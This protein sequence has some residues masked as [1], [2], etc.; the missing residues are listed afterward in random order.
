MQP[1]P[2]PFSME[3]IFEAHAAAVSDP[4]TLTY[5][6]AMRDKDAPK[7][8]ASA[9]G[10]LL[11]LKKMNTWKVVPR[12]TAKTKILPGLWVFRRKRN[13]GT[14]EI[15]KYKG[16]Y[17]VR[18]DLQHGV[19]DTFAPVVQWSTIRLMMALS[20]RY[21]LKTRCLDFSS[22]FVQ[23][24]LK[25]PVWIHLA[26]GS[27]PEVFGQN[28]ADMC[29]EL[30]R[31]L[32]GLSVAPKLWYQHFR[33]WLIARG[34]EPSEFDPC[35]FFRNGVAVAIYVDD[36]IMIGP[37]D[38]ELTDIITELRQ[39]FELTDEGP[40]SRYLGIDIKRNSDK[41]LLS[42]PQLIQKII[43]A[44]GM[45][46]CNTNATPATEVLGSAKHKDKHCE[47]WDYSSVVGMLMYLSTNSRPDIA[48]AVHQC[49]RFT[50]DPRTPHSKAVKQIVRYLKG[51]QNKGLI[52]SID[53]DPKVD[54]FVDADF[55]GGFRKDE[56]LQDPAT[57]RSRTGYTIYVFGVPIIWASKL[58]TEIALSTMESEYIALSAAAREVLALR[59]TLEEMG[60]K[61]KF[62]EKFNFTAKSK[63]FEDNN[64]ALT[65]A[66][67]KY[68][69]P[70]SKHYATKLHFFR[71]HCKPK[72]ILEIVKIGT[73]EQA[74][75]IFTKPLDRQTFEHVRQLLMGW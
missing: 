47:P 69:T 49:A 55:A 46:H 66:T 6:E 50:H 8:R 5:E 65:L 33:E 23:A 21:K 64:G 24:K 12:S 30:K 37:S 56:D 36:V 72:G 35:L 27:F 68:F 16:R 1:D 70:R 31:S 26:R 32:Y 63:I 74:A 15:V 34:F 62:Q 25:E 18:G 22:A 58:Q 54:C 71:S 3:F 19:F 42:Q 44:T 9:V 43:K 48:F 59:N 14:G 38:Q 57:A 40:L 20:L 60:A 13:P 7:F 2:T 11:S 39:E 17:T 45:Q 29:L 10:E 52:M 28:T 51:T 41:F 53:R 73:K 61:L 4:D 75:D 67:A